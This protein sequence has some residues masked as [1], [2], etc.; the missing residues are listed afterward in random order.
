MD[1]RRRKEGEDDL[2]THLT[3]YTLLG[4]D[5]TQDE[6]GRDEMRRIE[7]N[8]KNTKSHVMSKMIRACLCA[9]KMSVW[10]YCR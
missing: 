9:R 5:F 3:P 1:G 2:K 6:T 7:K 4:V 10:L 8:N